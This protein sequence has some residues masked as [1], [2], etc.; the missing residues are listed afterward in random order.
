MGFSLLLLATMCDLRVCVC[1]WLLVFCELVLLK[2]SLYLVWPA[3]SLVWLSI[4][5]LLELMDVIYVFDRTVSFDGVSFNGV[6]GRILYHSTEYRMC[7]LVVERGRCWLS[8]FCRTWRTLYLLY[9]LSGGVDKRLYTCLF[10]RTLLVG[11]LNGVSGLVTVSVVA[12]SV[13][14]A[15]LVAAV[16][17][18]NGCSYWLSFWVIQV[19]LIRTVWTNTT[20]H[21]QIGVAKAF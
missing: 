6:V 10:V 16:S 19:I 21:I 17:L 3:L 2:G 15:A 9:Q 11:L 14:V 13:D 4:D 20:I 1:H 18:A 5:F 12:G 8:I 7:L